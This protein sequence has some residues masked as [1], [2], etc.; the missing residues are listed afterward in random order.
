MKSIIAVFIFTLFITFSF[1]VINL[2]N[3]NF[4]SGGFPA[5][6]TMTGP[7]ANWQI[8]NTSNAG[9]TSPELKFANSPAT[10]GLRRYIS[11]AYNTTNYFEL[12]LQFN[13]YL[14]DNISSPNSY[15]FGVQ[16]SNNL[17]D[18]TDIWSIG[19]TDS[20]GPEMTTLVIP[21]DYLDSATFHF[22]FYFSG[23]PSDLVGWYIDNIQLDAT[24]KAAFGNWTL[25]GSPY[26][27]EMD[28][29]VPIGKSLTIYPGVQVVALGQFGLEAS[30]SI[31]AVGTPA[32][33]IRFTAQD[34]QLGWKGV[35]VLSYV[36][37]ADSL[38]FKHCVFEW[39]NGYLGF[40]SILTVGFTFQ[41]VLIQDCRFSEN[42]ASIAAAIYCNS[43]N[44]ITVNRCKLYNNWGDNVT[45]LDLSSTSGTITLSNSLIVHNGYSNGTALSH[46]RL[47]GGASNPDLVMESNT[48]AENQGAVYTCNVP[49]SNQWNVLFSSIILN[50]SILYNPTTTYELYFNDTM[51]SGNPIINYCDIRNG[52]IYGMSP[53][54]NN[55]I[56]SN[57][58]FSS[59]TSFG[60][61]GG[62]PCVDAGNPALTDPDGSRK[63]MGA[64]P[65]W[66]IP[67]ILTVSDVPYD[68]G[69]KVKVRWSRSQA[70]AGGY[71]GGYYS[72][73]RLDE[74][75]N[76]NAVFIDSPLELNGL[77][78][79]RNLYWHYRDVD[80]NFMGNVPAYNFPVY[81]LNCP[82]LQ[83]SSSTGTHAVPFVVVYCYGT[84]FSVSGEVSGYSVDNIPPDAVRNLAITKQDTQLRLDWSAV[85]NGTYNGNSYPEQNGI[86]YMIYTSD[87]PYFEPGPATY[88]TTTTDV[89]Q[90]VNYLASS[91]KFFRI[92][93]TDQ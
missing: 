2:A 20:Y 6:W 70:D 1:A 33:S 86:Y 37:G 91:K 88:L 89:F 46:I 69:L 54:L 81:S 82:T 90:L 66:K 87:E 79:Q 42:I 85:T 9:G 59:T 19:T 41:N 57:P 18:W 7:I 15:I 93:T 38:I 72:V 92:V 4:N 3:V 52:A 44:D 61:S 53:I 56:Y 60:L 11:P 71:A 55:T 45:I 74:T 25:A 48:I 24:K 63:D 26:N 32:D 39:G 62:S 78:N 47:R 34:H 67:T 83:D 30:G 16:I 58:L 8:S 75:R 21:S 84:W 80:Y 51:S 73:F 50:N 14:I 28:Y 23:T 35:A 22:A 43:Y 17:T 29:G 77:T 5:G 68:Q 27:L 10:A 65:L 13:Q 36:E 31:R 64:V 40:G 12:Q 49:G 76:A